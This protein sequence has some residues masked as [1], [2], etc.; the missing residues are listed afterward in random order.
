MIAPSE[1]ARSMYIL[2]NFELVYFFVMLIWRD[3]HSHAPFLQTTYIDFLELNICT[4][5]Q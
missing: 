5:V 2:S 1:S 3:E 4:L